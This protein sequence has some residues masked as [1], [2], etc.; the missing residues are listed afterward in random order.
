[1]KKADEKVNVLSGQVDCLQEN[2]SSLELTM[3]DAEKNFHSVFNDYRNQQENLE[4]ELANY[5][6]TESAL[7]NACTD[8]ESIKEELGSCTNELI[9]VC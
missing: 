5:Q 6:K 1:M 9:K 4:K 7:K 8:F 2:L 3:S